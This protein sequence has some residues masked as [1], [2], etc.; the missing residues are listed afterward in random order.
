MIAPGT[1]LRGRDDQLALLA[2]QLDNAVAG[3]GPVVLIEAR[4]GLGKTGLLDAAARTAR[5]RGFAVGTGTAFPA[6]QAVPMAPMLA[7]L[8]D[9]APPVLDAQDRATLLGSSQQRY[10]LRQEL[11]SMLERAAPATPAWSSSRITPAQPEASAKA[12][13]TRTTVGSVMEQPFD[14]EGSQPTTSGPPRTSHEPAIS[15]ARP[16]SRARRVA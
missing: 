3:R 5:G 15:S 13:C 11:A 1:P 16:A 2:D 7:A 10:W 8:V 12:P 9:G 4:P 14:W 6:E